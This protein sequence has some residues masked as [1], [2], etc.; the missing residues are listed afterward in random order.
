LSNAYRHLR[1]LHSEKADISEPH[2]TMI[3]RLSSD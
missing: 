2:G 3:L 1:A